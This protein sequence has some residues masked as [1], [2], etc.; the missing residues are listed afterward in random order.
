MTAV[1]DLL[2]ML[3]ADIQ[4]VSHLLDR[5]PV[6]FAKSLD[7]LSKFHLI[8]VHFLSFLRAGAGDS[9]RSTKSRDKCRMRRQSKIKS[10]VESNPWRDMVV[11]PF[12]IRLRTV[13]GSFSVRFPGLLRLRDL[14]SILVIQLW[15]IL[16]GCSSFSSCQKLYRNSFLH[17]VLDCVPGSSGLSVEHCYHTGRMIDHPLI[18]L[19]ESIV[20]IVA[21][22]ILHQICSF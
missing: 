14:K 16:L 4:I 21:A 11:P 13:L 15:F 18:P 1:L 6:L 12:W 9:K 17:S 20:G 2:V 5:Q 3:V 7:P 22:D 10:T 19:L 8:E